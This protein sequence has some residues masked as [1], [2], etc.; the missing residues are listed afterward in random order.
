MRIPVFVSCPTKL[1]KTQKDIKELIFK[2]LEK[3]KLE[4][5]TLGQSD[6]PIELPL[7]EVFV[8][9][10]HCAG[11]LILGFKQFIANGGIWKPDTNEEKRIDNTVSFPTPWNHL[12]AGI[13]YSL[14]LPLLVFKEEGIEGGIFDE[15]VTEVFVYKMPSLPLN[16]NMKQQLSSIF[17][18][19]QGEVRKCYYKR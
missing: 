17:L 18:R 2:E 4:P 13:L 8:L 9:A 3:Y 10:K 12:E 14:G 15:G 5:R 6:Y 11:G 7:R 1:S 19:W 16:E